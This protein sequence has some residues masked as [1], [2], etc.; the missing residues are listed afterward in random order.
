M[1]LEDISPT[2]KEKLKAAVYL[3]EPD[4][5]EKLLALMKKVEQLDMSLRPLS[6]EPTT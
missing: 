3:T 4:S 1:A 5:S 6:K 2:E